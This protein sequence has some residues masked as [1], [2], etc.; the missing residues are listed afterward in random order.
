MVKRKPVEE[1]NYNRFTL[2]NSERLA[3]HIEKLL[4]KSFS[5]TNFGNYKHYSA[6]H[7][8]S[9]D[10][11]ADHEFKNTVEAWMLTYMDNKVSSFGLC[12]YIKY[13][14]VTTVDKLGPLGR[15]SRNRLTHAVINQL[16]FYPDDVYDRAGASGVNGSYWKTCVDR[17]IEDIL[18][19]GFIEK[20]GVSCD[21]S[22]LYRLI[23]RDFSSLLPKVA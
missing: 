9:R 13:L 11:N 2:A 12:N 19:E 21:K 7:E 17:K 8:L 23:N 18:K 22:P 15:I 16:P 20:I 1:Y 3:K 5:E 10:M 6:W 14:L 4:D